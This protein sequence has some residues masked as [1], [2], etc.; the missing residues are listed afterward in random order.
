MRSAMQAT[1]GSSWQFLTKGHCQVNGTF[2][3]KNGNFPL[4]MIMGFVSF[5]A[6]C[7]FR[8][9]LLQVIL[10]SLTKPPPQNDL[11]V[12]QKQLKGYCRLV[13]AEKTQVHTNNTDSCLPDINILLQLFLNLFLCHLFQVQFLC[14]LI[15]IY[16]SIIETHMVHVIKW[17]IH[18]FGSSLGQFGLLGNV[19]GLSCFLLS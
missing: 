18:I 13:I 15:Y 7:E 19:L 6:L 16:H 14:I 12:L 4:V 2:L 9:I 5:A 8:Q 17:Y 3:R 11:N 10:P 1:P